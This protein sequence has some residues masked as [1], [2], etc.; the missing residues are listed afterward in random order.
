MA[1]SGCGGRAVGV[2]LGVRVRVGVRVG[3]GEGVLEGVRVGLAQIFLLD[4]FWGSLGP[5]KRKSAA[6]LFE[7]L[8]IPDELG[9]RS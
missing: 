7:S 5:R 1:I 2:R 9:R 4:E 8:Q 6:L 3:V